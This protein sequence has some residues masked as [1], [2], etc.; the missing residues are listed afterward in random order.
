MAKR[1]PSPKTQ[2]RKL[3]REIV[4]QLN[5]RAKLVQKMDE[6]H[7]A[8]ETVRETLKQAVE[9]N[10][11]PLGDECVSAV[12][13]E[14]LSGTRALVA[15][16]KVAYLGP[17]YSY[18]H[19]AAVERFGTSVELVP[20]TNIAAVFEDVNRGAADCGVV[21]VENSTDG[22]VVDTLDMFV[23]MPVRICGEVQLRIH[24]NLLGKGTR[25]AIKEVYSKPQA[26]SQCRNW[27][28]KHMPGARAVET[29]STAAAAQMA[30]GTEG[31]AAIASMQAAA[32]YGLEVLADHIEDNPNNVTRFAI[33][34]DESA[35]RTGN[36]KTALMYE[37]DHKP[38]AL[39][40]VMAIFKR[41]RLN[42]TWIESFPKLGSR[43]EYIFFVEFEGHPA[44]VRA[45]RALTSLNKKA[46][47]V[48]ILGSY[49]KT[50]PVG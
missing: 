30:A 36:D 31:V 44:E 28:A 46:V 43:N 41:N 49:E 48:E 29:G 50:E 47:R 22:R 23:K 35:R 33:I 32:S 13:R 8:S 15:P 4:K 42:L 9:S 17:M 40:D 34:G 7:A 2:L 12:F 6:S 14:L 27:L 26:I 18:S 21:P 24:H 25:D 10:K 16:L 37:L 39:A 38:G 45:K 11:G 1:N 20:V 19:I 5:E 3:D